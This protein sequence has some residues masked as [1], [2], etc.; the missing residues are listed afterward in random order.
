MLGQ[1]DQQVG[2]HVDAGHG[3]GVVVQDDREGGFVCYFDEVV[4]DGVVVHE[5]A[6][7][8]GGSR[9]TYSPPAASESLI[10]LMVPR[11]EPSVAPTMMGIWVK[12][13]ESRASLVARVTAVFSAGERW[14]ASPF[15]PI[16]TRPTRPDSARRMAW[17]LM[18]GM[19][20]SSVTGSKNVIVG[21]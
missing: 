15:E 20:R 19:S 3:A 12:P 16:V 2:V 6:E 13:A 21:A 10:R 14:T 9:S 5:A 4:V 18:V 11:T 17:R 8:G 1:A 7:I